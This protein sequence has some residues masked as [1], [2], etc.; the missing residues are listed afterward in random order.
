MNWM[1]EIIRHAAPIKWEFG[2]SRGLGN[3]TGCDV[4]DTQVLRVDPASSKCRLY[5][6]VAE[7]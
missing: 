2:F 3:A 7:H 1:M 5:S 6:Q 4:H